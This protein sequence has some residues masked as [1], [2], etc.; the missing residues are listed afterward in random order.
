MRATTKREA[1]RL[2]NA[3]ISNTLVK[4]DQQSARSGYDVFRFESLNLKGFVADLG[5][6]LELTL[7]TGSIITVWIACDKKFNE[8]QLEDALQVVKDAID[9]I[10]LVDHNLTQITGIRDARNT[11]YNA[12]AVIAQIL[13]EQHPNSKLYEMFNLTRA[14]N[15]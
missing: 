14:A 1:W 2:V 3:I 8:W 5:D 4:D 13:D 11:L 10:D 15:K 9:R 7:S 6:R 12:Y